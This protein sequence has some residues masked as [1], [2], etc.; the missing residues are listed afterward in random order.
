M[1]LTAPE[2]KQRI[3]D[4]PHAFLVLKTLLEWNQ[5]VASK[6]ECFEM[7]EMPVLVEMGVR[8]YWK[9]RTVVVLE[10]LVAADREGGAC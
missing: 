3:N 6:P 7:E 5:F 8:G 2:L 4:E 10:E 1:P 9:G